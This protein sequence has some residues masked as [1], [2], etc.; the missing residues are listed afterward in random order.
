VAVFPDRIVLKNSTDSQAA[1]E[2]AIG[3]GGTD[4]IVQGELVAGLAPGTLTL[5][6]LDGDGNVVSF[7]PGSASGRAIV[8]DTAPTIG[9]NSQPLAEGDLWYE[10]DTGSY[11]VYYGATWAEVSGGGGAVDSVNGQTG[12]VALD[13]AD[14]TDVL[15]PLAEYGTWD[16]V[17]GGS[18]AAYTDGDFY[19]SGGGTLYLAANDANGVSF[20]SAAGGTEYW[21]SYDATNWTHITGATISVFSGQLSLSPRT[22]TSNTAPTYVAFTEPGQSSPEFLK[23]DRTNSQYQAAQIGVDDMSDVDTSTAAPTDGQ[24]L[25]WVDANGQWEPAD[26]TGG[27][28]GNLPAVPSGGEVLASDGIQWTSLTLP[29]LL[30]GGGSVGADIRLDFEGTGDTQTLVSSGM[31]STYPSTDAKFGSGGATFLRSNADYLQGTWPQTL[32]T[33]A[34]T[35]SFWVKTSDTDYGSTTGRRIVAPV[36]GTNLADGFQVLRDSA[37]GNTYTPHADNAQGAIALSPAGD[38]NKY[39]CSTR[40]IDVADGNWHYVVIQH[41]GSGVYSCFF[42]G[43]LTERRAATAAVDFADNGGFFLG[44]RQDNNSN[45]YFTGS[46]DNY[47]LEIGSVL[48]TGSTV[49]VPTAPRGVSGANYGP[50]VSIDSLVDVD[51]ATTPPT[52]GQVLTWVDANS[53]WEAAD[54]TGGG[55]TSLDSLSDVDTSTVPPTDGQALVWDDTNSQWEPGTVSGG[56]GGATELNDLSDVNTRR[57]DTYRYG[58]GQ[59]GVSGDPGQ[60]LYGI[61]L[62]TNYLELNDIDRDGKDIS[63]A[64]AALD[65]TTGPL[66]LSNDSGA[67]W[68]SVPLATFPASSADK[69]GWWSFIRSGSGGWSQAQ[70]GS[71]LTDPEILITADDP[72]GDGSIVPLDGQLLRYVGAAGEWWAEDINDII[73]PLP[74]VT[75]TFID[76]DS[77]A[78]TSKALTA[79]AHNTGDL[80]VACIMSRNS[81]GTLTPPSGFTLHGEYLSSITFSGDTQTISVFTKTATA[82][83]PATYTWTQ[84]SSARICGFIAAVEEGATI[85]SVTEN[86][87]NAATATITTIA[88]RLNITAATWVYAETTLGETYSQSGV[89]VTEITDSP[90]PEAR[91]SGGYTTAAGTVT[92]THQTTT[93][94]DNPNHGMINIALKVSASIS[95]SDDVDTVTTPPAD[96]QVLTWV[97]ANNQW[98]PADATGAV[99][100]VNGETG[101]VS[102]G[103]GNLTDVDTGADAASYASTAVLTSIAWSNPAGGGG[104]WQTDGIRINREDGSG[105][106][107]TNDYSSLV[108]TEITIFTTGG[109]LTPNGSTTWNNVLV[110]GY[111]SDMD[112]YGGW[113]ELEFAASYGAAPSGNYYF[114]A[115][116]M[117]SANSPADGEILTWVEANGKWEPVGYISKAALKAE[118]AASA[119]FADF[120]SRI[121]AL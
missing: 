37:G 32:G 13:L 110:T 43:T 47:V 25:T 116:S 40:T 69:G 18:I 92:S 52:D 55:A 114:A 50:G 81:G 71:A 51:T 30:E 63:T 20:L 90:S 39:L 33:Q 4:P 76:S 45:G 91:I 57:L 102:L 111:L 68:W 75:G 88:N 94:N 61:P 97:D 77:T 103:I 96:G 106:K 56:G 31:T 105:N 29:T 34:F 27:G 19:A 15:G 79:P 99:D 119:D 74:T 44:K 5:Y 70:D 87:G 36:S 48:S 62:N 41:E 28:S 86:Y 64:L 83:E 60:G 14:L 10:S 73:N 23:Y 11:Y 46:I 84:A 80:L 65:G 66:Y 17:D 42:D 104:F 72:S 117:P 107:D 93:A 113:Y 101:V 100:S 3:S 98:E 118:V 120:Q 12:V 115:K 9:I 59:S 112:Q 2:T 22:G 89:S 49:P 85:A 16:T 121:A 1:I 54:A 8:S 95:D 109:D 6:S 7:S 108:G 67:T 38:A 78:A 21:Y 58:F 35:L 82:S 53:Q 24:V 26:A